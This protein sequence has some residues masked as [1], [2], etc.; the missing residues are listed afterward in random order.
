MDDTDLL[1]IGEVAHRAGLATSALR[2]YER[3]GLGQRHPYLGRTAPL[4]T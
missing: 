4:S 1:T 2:H 3:Q